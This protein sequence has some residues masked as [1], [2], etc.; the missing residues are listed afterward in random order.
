MS[1]PFDRRGTYR[2][3]VSAPQLAGVRLQKVLAHAGV[4]SRRASEGLIAQ[5]RVRVNGV[6]VDAPGVLVDPEV[7]AISVD[8]REVTPGARGADYVYAIVN[9]PGGVVSTAADPQGRPTVLDLVDVP[10]RLYP[11]GRL[12]VDTEGLLLLTD[13]GE[14]TYRLTH[15]SFEVEKEYHAIVRCSIGP[16][17]IAALKEGVELDDGP[18]RA[19]AA[20]RLRTTRD[21]DLVR[22]VLHEGRKREVRRML[23][24]VECPVVTLRRVRVGTLSLGDLP[25]GRYRRLTPREVFDLRAEVD[26][27][28]DRPHA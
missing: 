10:R 22:I 15:P 18:A 26:L 6:V 5:G 24:Y 1:P 12:D 8:G 25:V 19:I 16:R 3:D 2:R 14:L 7:D 28:D 21:G 20:S 9:K 23:A 11:V 17:Q 4:A 13:D 27:E